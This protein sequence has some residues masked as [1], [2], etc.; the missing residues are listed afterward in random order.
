[1]ARAGT[2]SWLHLARQWLLNTSTRVNETMIGRSRPGVGTRTALDMPGRMHAMV[3]PSTACWI[4][5][6]PIPRRH[7][8]SGVVLPGLAGNASALHPLIT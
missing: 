7:S 6:R 3:Q 8:Q 4:T 1:M 5:G 2:L